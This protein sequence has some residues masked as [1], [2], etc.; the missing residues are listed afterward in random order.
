MSRVSV[1]VNMDWSAAALVGKTTTATPCLG[2]LSAGYAVTVCPSTLVST[3]SG[4]A[5]RVSSRHS[6]ASV[7]SA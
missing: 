7:V 3:V 6:A 2:R 1:L 5:P 4:M